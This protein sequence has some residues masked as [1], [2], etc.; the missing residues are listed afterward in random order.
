MW[1]EPEKITRRLER[2]YRCCSDSLA[3]RFIIE[4]LY[5]LKN[6]P[7]Y[8]AKQLPVMPKKH[9]QAL[10]V[11]KDKLPMRK[12]KKDFF[13]QMFREKKWPFLATGWTEIESLTGKRTEIIMTAFWVCTPYASNSL[14]IVTAGEKVFTYLHNT[15]K[16]IFPVPVGIC[17]IIRIT[18]I[19]EM[20]FE[21]S[22][23]GISSPGN[24]RPGYFFVSRSR[25]ESHI[26]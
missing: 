2:Y 13:G 22:M 16:A 20:F 5:H 15:I 14:H 23:K 6:E 24:V 25:R 1:I 26:M 18:K 11:G 12:I 10:G 21:D 19:L 17:F 8:F 3:C 9:A 4:R 7:W